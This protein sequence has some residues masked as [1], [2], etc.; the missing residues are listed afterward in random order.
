MT[1]G[2]SGSHDNTINKDETLYMVKLVF[3]N[4]TSEAARLF[5]KSVQD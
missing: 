1:Y 2:I 4:D 3:I 5:Y